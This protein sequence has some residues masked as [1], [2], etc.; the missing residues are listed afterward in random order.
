MKKKL[1]RYSNIWGDEGL[2]IADSLDEAKAMYDKEYPGKEH[3]N[4]YINGLGI[5]NG[6]N[7]L[8]RNDPW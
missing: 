5:V 1:Y 4:V 2:I 7:K 3:D 8:Y 6:E